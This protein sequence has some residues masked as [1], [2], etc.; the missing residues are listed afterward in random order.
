[1]RLFFMPI[2][3]IKVCSDFSI[4]IPIFVKL[5]FFTFLIMIFF[6]CLW[7]NRHVGHTGH[8]KDEGHMKHTY[9]RTCPYCGS[10]NDPG[11]RCTCQQKGSDTDN[12]NEC[13]SKTGPGS[14][15]TQV[16]CK[17]QRQTA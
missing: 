8:R 13:R 6:M 17:Q 11:E 1:M 12:G 14:L 4:D 10:H 2:F 7:Y 15:Q 9:Y 3:N 5:S 16:V